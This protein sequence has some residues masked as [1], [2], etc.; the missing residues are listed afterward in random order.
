MKIRLSILSLLSRF[1]YEVRKVESTSLSRFVDIKDPELYCPLFSPWYAKGDFSDLYQKIFK[2][3]LVSIEGCYVIYTLL[4][5]ALSIKGD[6]WECGVY[7]GGTAYLM[8]S[9]IAKRKSEKKLFLFDTF[10]GMPE[11]NSNKDFHVKGDFKNT[12]LE[13]VKAFIQN[14][15][16]CFYQPGLIPETFM[17]LEKRRIA[18]AHI[19]LD[20]YQSIMDSLTFIWPRLSSGGIILF[21]DYGMP[22]CAGARQAVD[23]F[24]VD[25][26]EQ[27]LC[28]STGQAMVIKLGEDQE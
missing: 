26:K 19:D 5:Q 17:G 4:K 16:I 13:E 21:D 24:F 25:K 18:M 23:E 8:S 9:I 2:T 20:I 6:I 12:S 3:T 14:D 27:P 28:L 15:A 7:R 11:T 22:T 10:S 1:G